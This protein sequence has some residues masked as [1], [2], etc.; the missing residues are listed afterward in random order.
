MVLKVYLHLVKKLII[1]KLTCICRM[2][3]DFPEPSAPSN[4][5]SNPLSSGFD[6]GL[7]LCFCGDGGSDFLAKRENDPTELFSRMSS[8]INYTKNFTVNPPVTQ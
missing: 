3:V 2:K 6:L 4:R 5:S 8:L 1:L 7:F